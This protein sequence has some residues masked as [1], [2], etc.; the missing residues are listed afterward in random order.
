MIMQVLYKY[1][2]LLY[3]VLFFITESQ[4]QKIAVPISSY[5][6]WD[7]GGGVDD[8]SD[9]KA[10]F[11]MGIEVSATWAEVQSI[12]PSKFDFSMFQEVLDKAAKYH[13]IVKISINVGPN[14][15]L[16]LYD[17]GVPLVKVKSH[18]PEK[19]DKKFGNYLL[20]I[21]GFHEHFFLAPFDPIQEIQLIGQLDL[22]I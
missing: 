3:Y 6:V 22:L 16:W 11:V 8:Y 18:K 4:A 21:L 9:P 1:V 13:K 12:G 17:N 5:G 10:D 2:A 7:R 20:L 14:S 19:H 15:P